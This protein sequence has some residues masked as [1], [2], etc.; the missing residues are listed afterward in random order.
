V[1]EKV[2]AETESPDVSFI[3]AVF[4]D[5]FITAAQWRA[6]NGPQP[7]ATPFHQLLLA[8]FEQ[9]L[10]DYLVPKHREDV[11]AW[12]ERRDELAAVPF[13]MACE[14]LDFDP[15]YT[16]KGFRRFM[17]QVDVQA[18]VSRTG[19]ISRSGYLRFR[20]PVVSG[21]GIGSRKSKGRRMRG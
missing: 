15:A 21:P 9:A 6:Q 2:I 18:L 17:A 5:E 11:R 1:D 3:A 20:T 12:V 8:V 16:R 4:G 13:E 7:R 14:Y 19:R 10:R